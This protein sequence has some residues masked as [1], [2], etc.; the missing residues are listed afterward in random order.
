MFGKHDKPTEYDLSPRAIEII[1][2]RMGGKFQVDYVVF[3]A[4]FN[5]NAEAKELRGL[6]PARAGQSMRYEWETRSMDQL[7][8][9]HVSKRA[10]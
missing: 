6:L 8:N 9:I 5:G 4:S 3:D 10:A 2:A 1:E 7:H